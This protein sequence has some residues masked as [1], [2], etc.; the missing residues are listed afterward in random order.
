[1]NTGKIFGRHSERRLY[2]RQISVGRLCRPLAHATASQPRTFSINDQQA[3]L[4]DTVYE[5]GF[6]D[7]QSLQFEFSVLGSINRSMCGWTWSTLATTLGYRRG[8]MV[9]RVLK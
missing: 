6:Y 1:M 9:S 5:V 8:Q 2:V 3:S 7:V 4:D